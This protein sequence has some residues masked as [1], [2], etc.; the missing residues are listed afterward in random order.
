M[1][2]EDALRELEQVVARLESAEATLEESI[3]LFARGSELRAHCEARLK[4]AEARVAEI[5]Q[6][7]DGTIGSRPVEYP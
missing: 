5:T 3:T 7:A 4:A 6:G 2:F 1:S